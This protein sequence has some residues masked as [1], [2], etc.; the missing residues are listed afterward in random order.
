MASLP[1][2]IAEA[3]PFYAEFWPVIKD[4][5]S[6]LSF[7]RRLIQAAAKSRELK[8]TLWTM[9]ARD[10]LFYV[11]VFCFTH[12][13]RLATDG[14]YPIVPFITYEFQDEAIY[15]MEQALGNEDML[16]EKSRD[17]GASWLC[18]VVIEHDWHFK[19]HRSAL[20]LSAKED[21]VDK[22]GAPKSLFF[23]L[24]MIH[25]YLPGWLRPA[26]T[27]TS[28]KLVN[29]DTGSVIDGEATTGDMG[30]GGRFTVVLLDEFAS[31][32]QDTLALS[33]TRD[34]TKCR[35]YNST[36]A[37]GR[38][39]NC[40]FYK[41][42]QKDSL[43]KIRLHWVNHPDKAKGLYF[44]DGKP[45]S[46]WYDAECVRSSSPAEIACELD[47]DYAG[48]S[49]QFF[50]GEAISKAKLS[51]FKPVVKGELFFDEVSATKMVWHEDK[52]GALMLWVK[53]QDDGTWPADGSY[54]I[55]ADIAYGTGAS[56]S[57]ISVV[58]KKTGSKVAEWVSCTKKPYEW[59]RIS[60]AMARWF[61]NAFLVWEANGP[62][63]DFG[64][65]VVTLGYRN[66]YYR[67]NEKRLDKPSTQFPGWYA[68]PETR[69]A[70]LGKYQKAIIEGVY[71]NPS[72]GALSEC[73]QYIYTPT[74]GISHSAAVTPNDPSGAR[75][76]HAD[77]VVADALAWLGMNETPF[78]EKPVTEGYEYLSFGWR[79][80]QRDK[81]KSRAK[82][83]FGR[84][85]TAGAAHV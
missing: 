55:G 35:F 81:M 18:L 7:R 33:A 20:L 76:N 74:G 3:Y 66:I 1:P 50:S 23:K 11:N 58:D 63:R 4:M 19:D 83:L 2:H 8:E 69:A 36:P 59:A 60:V 54:A 6:N 28:M 9:C 34:T 65:N 46:P 32:A 48:A 80:E 29:N 61:N 43:K 62:G 52:D 10:T 77:R 71:K 85:A 75:A 12:D 57:A 51:C 67:Q 15:Q 47:I 25:Q 37:L 13:P 42:T 40:E 84:F 31:V 22:K 53:P 70:L 24:D 14:K 49:S 39:K 56:N 64:D 44:V 30:R 38:G 72:E 78:Y 41:L 82:G 27:R 17:M 45:H 16:I 21:L 26:L 68:T 79:Q 5:R 73:L